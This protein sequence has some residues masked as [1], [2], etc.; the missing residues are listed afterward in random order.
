MERHSTW[1]GHRADGEAEPGI[2]KPYFRAI[3]NWR[4]RRA[5][6]SWHGNEEP[7]CLSSGS[8]TGSVYWHHESAPR[9]VTIWLG[10]RHASSF[11]YRRS[12]ARLEG[13]F[14]RSGATPRRGYQRL[15]H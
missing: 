7:R 14:A 2:L 1:H 15:L 8:G 5:Y 13:T 10:P 11:R 6:R 12:T 9:T 3:Q 4:P